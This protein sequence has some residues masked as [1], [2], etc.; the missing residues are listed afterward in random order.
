MR[1]DETP[2]AAPQHN[3]FCTPPS[4]TF[5]PATRKGGSG[6]NGAPDGAQPLCSL[7]SRLKGK[8][9]RRTGMRQR[10]NVR[11]WRDIFSLA[12]GPQDGKACRTLSNPARGRPGCDGGRFWRPPLDS[13]LSKARGEA[14]ERC[15]EASQAQRPPGAAHA[16]PEGA[17]CGRPGMNER[18]SLSQRRECLT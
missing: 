7:R 11:E 10:K 9:P 2:P 3:G 15:G 5:G 18:F 4:R 14:W 17:G 1:A 6:P 13:S 12:C 16:R 8:S